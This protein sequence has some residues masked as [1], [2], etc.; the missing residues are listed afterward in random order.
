MKWLSLCRIKGHKQGPIWH[1]VSGYEPD[2]SCRNC[3]DN[4]G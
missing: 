3:G 2:M 1:N 4:L